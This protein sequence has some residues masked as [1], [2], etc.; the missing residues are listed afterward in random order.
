[1]SRECAARLRSSPFLTGSPNGARTDSD[2]AVAG[3]IERGA[4]LGETTVS[5]A[6]P[7]GVP[8]STFT[9]VEPGLVACAAMK[10]KVF[11]RMGIRHSG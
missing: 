9:S 6:G 1:M 8:V 5:G 2:P 3:V 7:D 11:G 10:T 4:C